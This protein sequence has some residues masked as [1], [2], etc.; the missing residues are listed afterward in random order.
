M[1]IERDTL[2]EKEVP[3]H[4]YWGIQT[5][6]AMENFVLSSR[7]VHRGLIGAMA[8]VKKAA[9]EA[10][11]DLGFLTT[12]Q[13][14]TIILACEEII[15]GKLH[16]HFPLDAFQGGA[17]TSTHMNVNE[18][19]ANRA[20]EMLNQ[21]K[22]TYDAL[23]PL[24][25]V[26]RHQSTN[27]VYPTA[28]KIASIYALRDLSQVVADLQGVLQVKEKQFASIL[29]IGRSELQEAVPMTLGMEFSAWAEAIARDRWRCFKCE[30]RLRVVNLGAT[31]IG[32]GLGADREYIFLVIEKLRV[33]TGLGLSRAEN[34]AGDTANADVYVEVSGILKALAC[35]LAKIST[36]LRLLNLLG[37][38]QI[39]AVQPGSSIMPGKVNPVIEE[40]VSQVAFQVMANDSLITQA[41]SRGSLQINEF[42]PLIALALLE[43]LEI[44]T[45]AVR[46]F[47]KHIKTIEAN[48]SRCRH[49]LEHSQEIITA[50]VPF[51]GYEHCQDILKEFQKIPGS[52]H[53]REFLQDK[54]G[55]ELVGQV[56]SPQNL[57]SLGYHKK[58]QSC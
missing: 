58:G 54:F 42:M 11:R 6:R 9:A 30:E 29:K 21:P 23:H 35:N 50:F 1:R 4:V 36:D 13:A 53:F 7:K 5:Q 39:P 28:L 34:L 56:L 24:D 33:L 14:R 22:G 45:N 16:D 47:A 51:I 26:N 32:T 43:S 44:L 25:H 12:D 40:A 10:N 17:G 20:L 57:L 8:M 41:A 31:A 37:E 46:I 38:I 18:V 19:I 49:Y 48:E 27:D 3:L 15:D 52:K 55:K 2:G